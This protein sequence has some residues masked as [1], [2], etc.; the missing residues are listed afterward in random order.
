MYVF[1]ITAGA[2]AQSS[3]AYGQGTGSVLLTTLQC[4]GSEAALA[5]C[6]GA[7]F[8]NTQPCQHSRDAGVV[9]QRRQCNGV[10]ICHSIADDYDY[11]S[12]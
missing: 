5:N 3:A 2:V 8:L 7:E 12:A 6:S 10:H 1:I 4:A 11:Y 9:C